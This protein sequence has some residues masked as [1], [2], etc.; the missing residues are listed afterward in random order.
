MF[1]CVCWFGVWVEQSQTFP[2]AEVEAITSAGAEAVTAAIETS[3][4]ALGVAGSSKGNPAGSNT[5]T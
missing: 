2:E 1:W 4:Q 5:V 3:A